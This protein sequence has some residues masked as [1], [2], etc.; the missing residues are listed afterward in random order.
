MPRGSEGVQQHI[1]QKMAK[2]RTAGW[3]VAGQGRGVA[4]CII[5]PVSFGT[6]APFSVVALASK[7]SLWYLQLFRAMSCQRG[8]EGCE[9]RVD[10]TVRLRIGHYGILREEVREMHEEY[11]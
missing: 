5:V 7:G 10:S 6:E 9:T 1:Q 11:I 2:K 4:Q 8:D 3:A